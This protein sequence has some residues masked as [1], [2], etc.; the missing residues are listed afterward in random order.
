[1]SIKYPFRVHVKQCLLFIFSFAFENLRNT[2]G[3]AATRK[4]YVL[5]SPRLYCEIRGVVVAFLWE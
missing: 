5:G 4:L 3:R 2:S 1:M